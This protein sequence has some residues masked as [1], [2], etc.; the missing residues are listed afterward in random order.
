MTKWCAPAKRRTPEKLRTDREAIRSLCDGSRTVL[1]IARVTGRG[2]GDVYADVQAIRRLGH[3]LDLRLTLPWRNSQPAAVYRQFSAAGKLL[4]VGSSCDPLRR[5]SI[6]QSQTPWFREVTA[7]TIEWLPTGEAALAAELEAIRTE[8][9]VH[10]VARKRR[11]S[12]AA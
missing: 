8:N 1:D 3:N 10:N 5:T 12:S 4:Y 11:A 9:P 6:H 2:H 7:I